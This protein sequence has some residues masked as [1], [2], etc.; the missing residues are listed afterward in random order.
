MLI[1][2]VEHKDTLQ[3]PFGYGPV[4]SAA[5]GKIGSQITHPNPIEDGCKGWRS[6]MIVGCRSMVLLNHWFGN[7]STLEC[8]Q[9][10]DMIGRVFKVT[11]EFSHGLWQTTFMRPAAEVVDT[12][13]VMDIRN[14]IYGLD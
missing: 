13:D 8:F 1:Y 2:R 5:F 7:L 10:N 11:K 14:F 4:M 3:G 12:F 6:G 9:R